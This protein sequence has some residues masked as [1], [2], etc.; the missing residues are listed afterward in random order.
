MKFIL[1]STKLV[2]TSYQYIRINHHQLWE[3]KKSPRDF[4]GET[5]RKFEIYESQTGGEIAISVE[6]LRLA[7]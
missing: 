1:I 3:I 6:K 2:I 7:V 4:P 5:G